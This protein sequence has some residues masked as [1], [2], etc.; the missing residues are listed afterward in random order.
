MSDKVYFQGCTKSEEDPTAMLR[1]VNLTNDAILIKSM[2]IIDYP[3]MDDYLANFEGVLIMPNESFRFYM[4]GDDL[5]NP[6]L[7][8]FFME[9]C[10]YFGPGREATEAVHVSYKFLNSFRTIKNTGSVLLSKPDPLH[11]VE[12]TKAEYYNEKTRMSKDIEGFISYLYK[13]VFR[14]GND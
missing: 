2:K 9:C 11:E 5:T 6:P 1:I 13:K 10:I 12:K 3:E 4:V 7:E 14:K 8:E